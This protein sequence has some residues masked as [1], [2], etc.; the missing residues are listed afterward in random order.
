ML[1]LIFNL[2]IGLGQS[3]DDK[4]LTWFSLLETNFRLFFWD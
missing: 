3:G 4:M 2:G 1:Y